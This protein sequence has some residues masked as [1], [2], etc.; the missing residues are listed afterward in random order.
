[1]GH[2]A[3]RINASLASKKKTVAALLEEDEPSYLSREGATIGIDREALRAFSSKLDAEGRH[4]VKIPVD[5]IVDSRLENEAYVAVEAAAR[6]L[7]ELEGWTDAYRIREGK[8]HLPLAIAVELAWKHSG[9]LQV[10]FL[11]S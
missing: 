3:E 9:L 5:V 7:R 2:E 11:V 6:A 8:M 1:M 4:R 10:V